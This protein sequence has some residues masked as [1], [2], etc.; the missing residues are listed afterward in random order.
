MIQADQPLS[1]FLA[2]TAQ[3]TDAAEAVREALGNR[4]LSVVGA[5]SAKPSED[6]SQTIWDTLARSNAMV[7]I[8]SPQA[9]SSANV[10]VEIGAAWAWQMPVYVVLISPEVSRVPAFL[11]K[12]PAYPLNRIDDIARS[13]L[14]GAKTLSDQ[15]QV[16]L[17][18]IYAG[19]QTPLDELVLSP[20]AVADLRAQFN[21]KCKTRFGA[22]G[23]LQELFRL[24]KAGRL[25]RIQ[26]GKN[27][28]NSMTSA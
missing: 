21:R 3:D 8:I 14:E 18:E 28:A 16:A 23:L 4:G 9:T 26:N 27:R 15:E 1:V 5:E 11:E 20:G 19:L 7:A 13:I 12:Y 6:W 2:F 17:A 10:L 25:P 22:E 24:R